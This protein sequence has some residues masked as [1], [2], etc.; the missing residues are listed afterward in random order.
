MYNWST[1]QKEGLERDVSKLASPRLFL[2]LNLPMARTKKP[3]PKSYKQYVIEA[4]ARAKKN[5]PHK[6]FVKICPCCGKILG[7]EEDMK[8][9][10]LIGR[11]DDV[12]V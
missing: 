2:H 8:R 9:K 3:Q 10:G 7:S 4:R 1:N 12:V 5:C 6:H 11:G